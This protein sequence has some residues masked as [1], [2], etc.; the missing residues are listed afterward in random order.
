MT[1]SRATLLAAA[2]LAVCATTAVAQ[3]IDCTNALTQV[4]MNH[5]AYLD[6]QAADAALNAAYGAAVAQ[7]DAA[8]YGEALRAAQRLWIPYRDAACHAEAAQYEGGSIQPLIA[9]SCLS[10]LTQDRTRD[11]RLFEAY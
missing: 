11:L 1:A 10:R 7:A 5:C 9:L 6:Y 8:D 2:S 4:E 3:D